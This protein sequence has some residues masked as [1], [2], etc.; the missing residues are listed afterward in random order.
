MLEHEK[1]GLLY[2]YNEVNV[3]THYIDRIFSDDSLAEKFSVNARDHAMRV[4]NEEKL[5]QTLI[6]IYDSIIKEREGV[7]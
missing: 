6:D 1:E 2:C 7:F 3:L 5:E 4:H